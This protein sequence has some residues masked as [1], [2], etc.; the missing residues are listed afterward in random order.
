[1]EEPRKAFEQHSQET[2]NNH[3]TQL[4]YTDGTCTLMY[5]VC[6]TVSEAR[7]K[8][9]FLESFLSFH[10][11]DFRNQI[12]CPQSWQQAILPSEAQ[13]PQCSRPRL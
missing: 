6:A 9:Y 11:V 2:Q 3:V 10:D 8:D 5:G 1:V 7:S 4:L 12:L 13:K